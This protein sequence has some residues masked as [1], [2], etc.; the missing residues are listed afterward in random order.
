MRD[1]ALNLQWKD[2]DFERGFITLRGTVAKKG[3]TETIPM[4]EQARAILA[5]LPQTK[6]PYVFPGRYDDK[7]RGNIT[8]MLRRVKEKAGLPESFRPLHGLRHSFAAW[9]ASSG[10]VQFPCQND[11]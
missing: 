2:L 8:D 10:Q 3:K 11:N 4:N 1:F 7:P 9:L 6:S 5:A